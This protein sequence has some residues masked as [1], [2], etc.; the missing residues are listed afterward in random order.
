MQ[1]ALRVFPVA[2]AAEC[3][4]Y[5]RDSWLVPRLAKVKTATRAGEEDA[6]LPRLHRAVSRN[7]LPRNVFETTDKENV[8][9]GLLW[10]I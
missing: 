3:V 5:P 10:S 4:Y 7:N 9:S 8:L 1:A 6:P 2:S